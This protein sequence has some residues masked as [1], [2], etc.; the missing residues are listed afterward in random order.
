MSEFRLMQIV[1][2]QQC[3][4]SLLRSGKQ[5]KRLSRSH[6]IGPTILTIIGWLLEETFIQFPLSE[7]LAL[8]TMKQFGV[9]STCA[10]VRA[11]LKLFLCWGNQPERRLRNRRLLPSIIQS[12]WRNR[13][14]MLLVVYQFAAVTISSRGSAPQTTMTQQ[15][16]QGPIL[17]SS[18]SAIHSTGTTI[19]STVNNQT[20]QLGSPKQVGLDIVISHCK[21]NTNEWVRNWSSVLHISHIYIY[22]KC[23]ESLDFKC[24]EYPK[25]TMCDNKRVKIYQRSLPNVGQEGHTWIYHMLRD[26]I[27]H[28]NWTAYLQ[29]NPEHGMPEDIQDVLDRAKTRTQSTYFDFVDLYQYAMRR[30][31]HDPDIPK[32]WKLRY[33]K[34]DHLNFGWNSTKSCELHERFKRT[35]YSCSQIPRFTFRGQFMV[36]GDIVQSVT[37]Q[38]NRSALEMIRAELES[39]AESTNFGYWLERYWI[40]VLGARDLD[41]IP[42]WRHAGSI[43][44]KIRLGPPNITTTTA[45]AASVG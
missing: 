26:D 23:N 11:L 40:Q 13:I 35:N 22:N 1:S 16:Q 3:L 34:R 29:G 36:S 2:I 45:T 20:G 43:R 7:K 15:R 24:D 25:S 33:S 9:N 37:D 6:Q 21:E 42:E 12:G 4:Q 38:K 41:L 17:R 31:V 44:K 14:V 18:P 10:R 19:D 8:Q 32:L 27:Q 30:Q 28:A 5:R 39:G